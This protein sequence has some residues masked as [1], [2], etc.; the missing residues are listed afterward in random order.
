[1]LISENP[2]R[3][4]FLKTLIME[5]NEVTDLGT[6]EYFLIVAKKANG[7][8]TLSQKAHTEKIIHKFEKITQDESRMRHYYLWMQDKRENAMVTTFLLP[9]PEIIGSV[10]YLLQGTRPDLAFC[11]SFLSQFSSCAGPQ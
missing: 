4:K 3:M 8:A 1:M 6:L 9:Y 5:K 11:V 2:E 7:K 10:Q